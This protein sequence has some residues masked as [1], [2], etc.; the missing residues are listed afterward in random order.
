[1][2]QFVAGFIGSPAMNFLSGKISEK[3]GLMFESNH[4]EFQF[5]LT[6]QQKDHLKNIK[7]K[8][9]TIGIRPEDISVEKSSEKSIE[10]K[11]ALDVIE[12]MGNES[13]IYFEVEKVQFI[14][15]VKPLQVLKTGSPINL[16]IDIQNIYLFDKNSGDHLS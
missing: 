3:N 6:D 12:P 16:F 8:E 10:L 11:R 2:N 7:G 4:S 13:F 5:H 1:V 14:G 9:I 15:R